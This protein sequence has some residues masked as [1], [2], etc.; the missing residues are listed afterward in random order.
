MDYPISEKVTQALEGINQLTSK[1]IQCSGKKWH[2]IQAAH[3]E[4][5][6]KVKWW[7][8]RCYVFRQLLRIQTG[9]KVK[10]HGNIKR[11]DRQCG[12]DNPMQH[13]VKDLVKLYK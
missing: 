9:K 8:E 3:N 7:L 6:P 12:I 13:F 1:L 10:N 5:S 2:K 11:F 4:F